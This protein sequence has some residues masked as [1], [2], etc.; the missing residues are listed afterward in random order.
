[1]IEANFP[2]FQDGDVEIRLSRKPED[3]YVRYSIVLS[4][5][6]SFF[7]ASLSERWSGLQRDSAPSGS[8]KW[9][10]QLQ[11]GADEQDL[12]G[13]PLPSRTVRREALRHC[14]DFRELLQLISC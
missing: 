4:L 6:S 12:T 11:F 5:H 1:M 10:Y 14:K 2:V 7:K 3:R 13:V 9:R 8:I